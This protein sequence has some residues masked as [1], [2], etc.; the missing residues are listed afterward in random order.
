M[1]S[2][3]EFGVIH[4]DLKSANVL[5]DQHQVSEGKYVLTGLFLLMSFLFFAIFLLFQR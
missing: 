2:I 1:A 3:Q 5:L 4:H